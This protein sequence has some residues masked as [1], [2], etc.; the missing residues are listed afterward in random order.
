VSRALI[1]AI[2]G[3]QTSTKAL[4]AE[5]D[6]TILAEGRGPACDHIHGPGGVETNRRGIEGAARSALAA[7]GR[8]APEILAVGMGLT[9]AAREHKATP[10]FES[11]V[12]GFCDA[13]AIWVDAD[14][15]SNLAGASGGA[16]GVV[17]IAG[18]GS[19]GYGIDAAGNEAVTAGLGYLLGDEGSAWYIG[20]RGIVAA[21]EAHDGRGEPT[22]LLDYVRERYGLGSV[23]EIIRVIYADGFTRDQ[24]SGIAPDIV[25][26]AEGDA[27]AARI[28]EDAGRRL[29]AIAIATIRRLH[30]PGEAVDVFPTGGV[31]AAGPRITG[32]FAREIA[33]AWPA[34][35]IR[36]PR[37]PPV[38]GALLRA[39]HALGDEV[40]PG[41]LDRIEATLSPAP[42]TL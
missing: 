9:S 18:G 1:L 2:D 24:V 26:M 22:T 32:P 19:I 27:V 5:R 12:R 13:K 42:G 21:V 10:I 14:Y 36:E 41:L 8:D 31:F 23:R 29:A 16:P 17:V 39:L 34:A 28:V 37:F 15:V 3:G 40:T 33:V 25:R 35:T 7:A 20:L 4:L 6:G 38:V 11:I 30:A